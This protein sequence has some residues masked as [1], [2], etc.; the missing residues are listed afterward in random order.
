MDKKKIIIIAAVV[1]V[2]IFLYMTSKDK[3][4]EDM[5][6]SLEGTVAGKTGK[7][8]QESMSAV[9]MSAED[10]AYNVARQKF[11]SSAGKYPP[12][13]W[14][15]EQIQEATNNWDAIRKHLTSYAQYMGKMD[16]LNEA[17]QAAQN[18][19][20]I[21]T[22][23]RLDAG[24]K[25]EYQAWLQKKSVYDQIVTICKKY[26]ISAA[27]LG[28]RNFNTDTLTTLNNALTK[29]NQLGNLKS[30]YDELNKYCQAAGVQITKYIG[31][32]KWYNV[33][34]STYDSAIATVKKLY[35]AAVESA[36]KESVN[37]VLRNI[38]PYRMGVHDSLASF[39][40]RPYEGRNALDATVYRDAVNFCAKSTDHLNAWK[41][42]FKAAHIDY[43]VYRCQAR[44]YWPYFDTL[45]GL[46]TSG[47]AHSGGATHLTGRDN[48]GEV[49]KV[50]N[51]KKAPLYEG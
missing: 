21:A 19:F 25:E 4:F 47:I 18:C 46:F 30:R 45:A 2:V 24:A 9:K 8:A 15:I 32:T 43:P 44:K 39:R 17:K 40:D 33:L 51:L 36:A 10:T 12:T 34:T 22:A 27:D 20:D 31:S 1:V 42:A 6:D 16:R 13:S 38:N 3:S 29:A 26:G 7:D 14:T 49:E 41:A 5:M 35:L 11:Y 23:E 37:A 50:Y 28:V 48:W